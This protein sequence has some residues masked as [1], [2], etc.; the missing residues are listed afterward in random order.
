MLKNCVEN[1]NGC[2]LIKLKKMFF[3]LNSTLVNSQ[4]WFLLFSI[5]KYYGW[6]CHPT[7]Y[8]HFNAILHCFGLHFSRNVFAVSV[9]WFR[10]D[11]PSCHHCPI[12]YH[13]QPLFLNSGCVGKYLLYFIWKKRFFFTYRLL[14]C[15][16]GILWKLSIVLCLFL[17][18]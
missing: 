1:E 9:L 6:G 7:A 4:G 5:L 17:G 3:F 14:Q 8:Q 2:Q 18:M 13:F 12:S 11:V 15:S 10:G 16:N